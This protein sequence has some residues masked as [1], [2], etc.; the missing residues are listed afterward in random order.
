MS[1]LPGAPDIASSAH[2]SA[3]R[4]ILAAILV[5]MFVSG[6][7][8]GV[9]EQRQMEEP[10]WWSLLSAFLLNFLTFCWFRLDRD[11][12]GLRRSMWANIAILLFGPVT[13]LV[14][15]LVSRPRGQK[16]RGLARLVGFFVLLVFAASLGMIAAAGIA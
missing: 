3:M 14:Y 15:V 13:I 9:A 10:V 12:R 7:M 8:S 16:L 4:R 5:T 2:A 1:T 6:L 11:A